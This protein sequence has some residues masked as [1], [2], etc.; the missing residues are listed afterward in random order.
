MFKRFV[1]ALLHQSRK[2]DGIFGAQ[3][4][5]LIVVLDSIYVDF[6][7]AFRFLLVILRSPCM[8]VLSAI[9]GRSNER[10]NLISQW[11]WLS[12]FIELLSYPP[13]LP[14]CRLIYPLQ[15]F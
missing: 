8:G 11:L 13:I 4:Y 14:I 1:N 15:R 10:T 12:L 7:V 9:S 5:A 6:P 2:M 3:F